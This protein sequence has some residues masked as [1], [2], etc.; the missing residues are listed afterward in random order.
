MILNLMNIA[1]ERLSKAS[2]LK[3]VKDA[4]EAINCAKELLKNK[5]KEDIVPARPLPP[6]HNF[7]DEE[8]LA[9]INRRMHRGIPATG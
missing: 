8:L 5:D 6:I 9:E 7:S 1:I 3:C 4:V 2:Q